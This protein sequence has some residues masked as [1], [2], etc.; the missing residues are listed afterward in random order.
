M[1]N[2]VTLYPADGMPYFAGS[3][4]DTT[5]FCTPG[6][7][8]AGVYGTY[9]KPYFASNLAYVAAIGLICRDTLCKYCTVASWLH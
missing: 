4:G 9:V 7:V 5:Q 2:G 6:S 1:I 8:M 3:R